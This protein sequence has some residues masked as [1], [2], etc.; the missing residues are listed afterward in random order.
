[1]LLFLAVA[2][3]AYG[4]LE[5]TTTDKKM[6]PEEAILRTTY[7]KLS[8]ADE[9]RIILEALQHTGREKLWTTR[10]N[11]ADGALNSRLTFDLSDFHFGKLK[12]IADHKIVEFDG[13]LSAI[14]GEVLDVT[15]SVFNYSVDKSPSEYVAYVKFAW[16]PSPYHSLSPVENWPVAKVLESEQFEGKKYTDYATYTVT[17]TLENKSRTYD[18]WMLF[19]RDEKGKQQ[20]YFIDSVTDP[21]AL[22]FAFEHSLYP[23]A[24][25]KSDLRTVPFV[26]KWLYD[27]ALSCR[28]SDSEK[29]K[30][31][32]VCCDLENGHCG[33][34]RSS[35]MPRNSRRIAP[36]Q[37]P[38]RVLPAA[39]HISSL[40][41]HPMMQATGCAQ[42]NS[43]TTFP[44]GLADT[45]EHNSGQH[46]FTANVVGS[47]TYTDGT[48][49]PGACN[50]QC[51][52]QSSGV[53]A[54]FGS[55]SGLVFVHATAKSDA[56]GGS[57]SNGGTA[58][59]QCQGT[60]AMTVRSCVVPC[61][62]SVSVTAGANGFG[63]TISFPPSAL[64]NDSSSHSVTC[65]PKS[66]APT[67]TPTPVKI[68]GC[69]TDC[70]SNSRTCVPCGQ[71][72]IVLDLDGNGF[73]LTDATNGVRFDISGTG[74]PIQMGWIAAGSNNAFLALP[75]SDGLVHNGQQLFGNFTPQ[76]PSGQPNGFA[77]LAVYDDPNKGGNGDG[78]ID[79][80]D[81]VFALLRLWI[82]ANHDGVSQPEELHTLP[83]LGVN[84]ISLNYKRDDKTDEY[85]NAF[86]YRTRLN[87]DGHTDVG[88]KAY[89]IFFVVQTDPNTAQNNRC[90]VPGAVPQI[91]SSLQTGDGEEKGSH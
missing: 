30:R 3:C 25:V 49:S 40:P 90:V 74:H 32:D 29:D 43:S 16:K 20:V 1:M 5:P 52:A 70:P 45:Q 51:S 19:G 33:V 9:T 77:A 68:P 48:P 79:A 78:I 69:Q 85:G 42:F 12:D 41:L 7:A 86:R 6:R 35:L 58:P 73:Y 39:F 11:L 89:D 60:S 22:L 14:D 24:F 64:W 59:I 18:A 53:P 67:P 72:P 88:K 37:K 54:E 71:S 31:M 46:N 15:P 47:C 56:S 8:F 81:E 34:A 10:P 55:L 36:H 2:A 65:Q 84:S 50:M 87:P 21:T 26:D 23:A 28:A 80:R 38:A 82:D 13:S 57:S 4:Q 62:T 75:G 27:N 76:P 44:H 83:S 63:V 66:T 61:S 17:V 91:T